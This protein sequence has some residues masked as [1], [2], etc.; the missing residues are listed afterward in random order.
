MRAFGEPGFMRIGHAGASRIVRGNTLA[1]FDAALELGVDAVEFDVRA[2]Q[3]RLVLAHTIFHAGCTACESLERALAH[4]AL[5]R[6]ARVALNVDVKHP[7]VEPAVLEAL[8]RRG[9]LERT[10]VSSQ[11]REVVDRVRALDPDVRTGVSV[12][13]RVARRSQ[14]WRDWRSDVLDGLHRGRYDA[15]MA[16]HGLVDHGL[17][18]DVRARA[19]A[20]FAWTV[21]DAAALRAL[22]DAGVDGVVSGDPRVFA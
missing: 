21:E 10:I 9:L 1:S 18:A 20:L 11:V 14:G 6:F 7:G 5:P 19:G 17:V 16:Y 4:L 22:R 13:G 15:V 2:W 3:G 8:R 12:G